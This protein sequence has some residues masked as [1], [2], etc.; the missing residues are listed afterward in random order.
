[1]VLALIGDTIKMNTKETV[2]INV[3][4]EKRMPAFATFNRDLNLKHVNILCERIKTK[5][6]RKGEEIKVFKC[7]DA[8]KEGITSFRDIC[9]N[10]ITEGFTNYYLVGDGQHRTYAVSEFNNWATENNDE[11]IDVPGIIAELKEE[12][13]TEYINDINV[14]RKDW[15]ARNYLESAAELHPKEE[16]LQVYVEYVKKGYPITTLNKIYCQ[17][18]RFGEAD[19]KLLCFGEKTKGKEKQKEVIPPHNIEVGKRYIETCKS[20][21]FEESEIAK[22]YMIDCFDAIRISN[23]PDFAFELIE[24][25]NPNDYSAMTKKDKL[26]EA[27]VIDRFG[28]MKRRLLTSKDQEINTELSD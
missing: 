6:Y 15:D 8:I 10:E 27:N 5:G 4:G 7:E 9:G 25:I 16:L 2:L 26:V 19:F 13:I 24:S 11:T 1:M 3:D 22:R 23:G 18:K 21:N 14:T 17:G 28:Y 20:K 12:A